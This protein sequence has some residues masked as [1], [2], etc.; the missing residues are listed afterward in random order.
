MPDAGSGR[1]AG[2]ASCAIGERGVV[3]VDECRGERARARGVP[4]EA[5]L[6]R[7]EKRERVLE[8][9]HRRR[10]RRGSRRESACSRGAVE[11]LVDEG[12]R[13]RESA[14]SRSAVRGVVGGRE[15]DCEDEEIVPDV[16]G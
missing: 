11:G 5:W 15:G 12:R 8:G 13:E 3:V 16:V 1:S 7:V 4:S 9:C 6:T 2:R 10:G 14:C